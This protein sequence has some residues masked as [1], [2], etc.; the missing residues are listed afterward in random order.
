VPFTPTIGG[1]PLGLG[2]TDPFDFPNYVKGCNPIH[3]GV[4]Y[5]NLNCFA[6]PTASELPA[7]LAAQC[8]PFA[9]AL[10]TPAP[11]TCTNLVGNAGRNSLVGPGL[12]NFDLSL[13]K[14]N[15]IKRISETF[16]VQFRVEIFNALNHANFNPPTSN[17]QIFDGSGALV[18]GA[19]NITG[20]ATT[21]RQIQLALKFVW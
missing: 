7:S 21:S 6:L 16:N 12:V 19:G 1:D 2:N 17:N 5:L 8:V 11:A 3:G 9:S 10:P 18:G 14:N 4:N 20:T 13:F 15:P